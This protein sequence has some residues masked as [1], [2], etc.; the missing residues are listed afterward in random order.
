MLDL[1]DMNFHR[2]VWD[3]KKTPDSQVGFNEKDKAWSSDRAWE[4]NGSMM[5]CVDHVFLTHIEA[6]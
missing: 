3:T 2:P 1:P 6:C 5:I 4:G